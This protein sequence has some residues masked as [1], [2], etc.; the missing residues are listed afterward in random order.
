MMSNTID[1]DIVMTGG[2]EH[3]DDVF[4]PLSGPRDND[5]DFRMA[6][7]GADDDFSMDRIA[8]RRLPACP[9]EDGQSDDADEYIVSWEMCVAHFG[10]L[11]TAIGS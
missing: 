10:T 7:I 11:L 5:T 3:D 1:T 6:R 8:E 9:G 2:G 4:R